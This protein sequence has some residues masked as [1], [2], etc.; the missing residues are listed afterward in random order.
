MAKAKTLIA[1]AEG[2][3]IPLNQLRLSEDNVRKTFTKEAIADMAKDIRTNGLI[4]SLSVRKLA[5]AEGI[6][7]HEVQGG[8][9][10]FRALQL[11]VQQKEL[12][13]DTPIPTVPNEKQIAAQISLAENV[14]REALN[15]I[16]EY[17]AYAAMKEQG[18]SEEDI[19]AANRVSVHVVKQRLRLGTASPVL[20]K[21]FLDEKLT[22]SNL[23]A[24]CV[25]DDKE[26]QEQVWKELKSQSYLNTWTIKQKLMENTVPTSDRR[27]KFVGLKAYENAGGRVEPDL[28]AEDHASYILDVALL[29]QL[30]QAKLDRAAEKVKAQGWAWAMTGVDIPYET[31]SAF[32]QITAENEE[33][34]EQEEEQLQALEAERDQI[35]ETPKDERSKKQ[36]KRLEDLNAEIDALEN[37]E[38]IYNPEDMARAG[39]TVEI[40]SSGKLNVTYGYLKPDDVS[41]EEPS[42]G[43][44]APSATGEEAEEEEGAAK[45]PDS[46]V[47]NL[48]IHRTASLQAALAEKPDVAFVAVIHAMAVSSLN[49]FGSESCLQIRAVTDFPS[50][51]DGLKEFGPMKAMIEQ[52]K[53]WAARLPSDSIKLWEAIEAMPRK[54]QMQLLAFLAATTVNV[55]VQ[56]HDNRSRQVNHSQ[57]LAEALKYDIRKDWKPTA[58]NFFSRVAKATILASVAEARDE[59][60]ANLIS[61][62]K[63]AAMATEAERLVDGTGWLPQPM[64]AEDPA[65]DDEADTSEEEAALS[66]FEGGVSEEE[67]GAS[68]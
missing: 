58:E 5:E 65:I 7:T 22:L 14:Q 45:I 66:D 8:G 40:D 49:M 25:T 4:Q 31:T 56:K 20:H 26:R 50:H 27:V 63:K 62:C 46:L 36:V 12:A 1:L 67:V 16:D 2:E 9:R 15:P 57:V 41:A 19:A 29:N 24:F 21:A 28:F 33:R 13:E 68:A 11:L 43:A 61:H 64:R 51:I 53:A 38:P 59:K 34:T 3:N 44:D 60:T 39:A 32:G 35:R 55:V 52:R 10:R 54:E 30:A 42:V 37:P 48:T 47:T 6:V 18:K 23:M 17:R